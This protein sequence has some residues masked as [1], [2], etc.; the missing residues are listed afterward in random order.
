MGML[1]SCLLLGVAA[2]GLTAGSG[3]MVVATGLGN[4]LAET[5]KNLEDCLE[6]DRDRRWAKMA[7]QQVQAEHGGELADPDYEC[8]F[9]DG[10]AMYLY[11]GTCEP[12]ALPPCKYMSLK[13]Q[14]GAGC[15]AVEQWRAGFR[16]GVLVARE[17]GQRRHLTCWMEPPRPA[18]LHPGPIPLP[19]P[20]PL[21]PPPAIVPARPPEQLPVPQ[22][23]PPAKPDETARLTPRPFPEEKRPARQQGPL[24]SK[25]QARIPIE[26]VWQDSVRVGSDLP[27]AA[28]EK[29]K[30]MGS[31]NPPRQ[32]AA[33]RP[34][35]IQEG[36][37]LD[38]AP[39]RMPPPPQRREEVEQTF[40]RLP[41]P[42]PGLPQQ[43]VSPKP[44]P[45]KVS[46]SPTAASRVKE[47]APARGPEIDQTF[48]RLPAPEPGQS[49][50]TKPA[51]PKGKPAPAPAQRPRPPAVQGPEIDQ[52]FIRLPAPESSR[53]PAA[54]KPLPKKEG[55]VPAPL[56]I[57]QEQAPA[58]GTEQY[59]EISIPLPL[60]ARR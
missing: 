56:P 34:L 44:V 46:P 11:Q 14:T 53:P 8:G 21:G 32:P 30:A 58:S 36:P 47:P 19:P 35:P 6:Q 45:T 54:A 38:P 57:A 13:Y 25:E 17:G 37:T 16:H 60:P 59:E 4:V 43:S 12:P 18:P 40:I 22:P 50:A 20:G 33:P 5:K 2:L 3:C 10:F 15:A 9:K 41:A 1:R 52:T 49:I 55:P 7:W 48:V 27:V 51:P 26:S 39:R 31:A 28:Q 24:P 29:P 42:E 23:V